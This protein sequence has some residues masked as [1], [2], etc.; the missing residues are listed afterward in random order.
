M[1]LLDRERSAIAF[2][3]SSYD[4][5]SKLDKNRQCIEVVELLEYERELDW[6]LL[7]GGE[8]FS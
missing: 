8:T 3:V 4:T 6:E 2:T 7:I 1:N 5:F